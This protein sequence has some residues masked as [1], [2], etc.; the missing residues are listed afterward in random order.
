MTST[1]RITSKINLY[2]DVGL[3]PV[4]VMVLV[5]FLVTE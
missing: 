2:S 3:L 4:A 1:A 5:E